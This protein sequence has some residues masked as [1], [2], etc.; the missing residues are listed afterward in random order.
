M[1][2][3]Q[4][5]MK[6]ELSLSSS[7][8]FYNDVGLK[9]KRWWRNVERFGFEVAIADIDGDVGSDEAAAAVELE[10]EPDNDED[11]IGDMFVKGGGG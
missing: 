3:T 6:E 7:S 2:K 11:C 1:Q 5:K 9:I 10:D 8:T 4:I